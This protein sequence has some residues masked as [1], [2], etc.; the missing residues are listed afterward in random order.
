M[1]PANARNWFQDRQITSDPIK[2]ADQVDQVNQESWFKMIKHLWYSNLDIQIC[3]WLQ[4]MK[5]LDVCAVYKQ[6][7]R[8]SSHTALTDWS[9]EIEY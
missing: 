6:H 7:L 2:A 5:I 8:R 3:K 1:Q 4:S 9:F